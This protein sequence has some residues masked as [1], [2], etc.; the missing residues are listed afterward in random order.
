MCYNLERLNVSGEDFELIKDEI[1]I[2]WNVLDVCFIV[3]E[4]F[5]EVYLCLGDNENKKVV[6]EEVEGLEKEVNNV[7]E[8]VE[9]VIKDI[10]KKKYVNVSVIKEILL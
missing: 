1:E 6:V 2:L 4:E 3:M 7:I 5:Q 8:K 9:Q 10:L